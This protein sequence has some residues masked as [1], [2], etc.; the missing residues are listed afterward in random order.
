MDTQRLLLIIVFSFSSIFLWERWQA[1]QHPPVV[2]TAPSRAAENVPAGGTVP[3]SPQVTGPAPAATPSA[4][5]GETVTVSTD[6]YT[7]DIDTLGAVITRVALA[8]HRDAHDASKP[9]V[10]LQRNEAR[11]FVAEAG[12]IGAGMPNHRTLWR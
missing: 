11:T 10:L 3:A 5:H 4:V 2:A 1:T 6:L 8:N 7:A 12:L 9:Y